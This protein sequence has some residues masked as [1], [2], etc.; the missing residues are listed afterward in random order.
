[1]NRD[2]LKKRTKEFALRIIKLV[3]ALPN[4]SAG[5]V[6]GNQ[7]L[8]SGTSLG[9]NYRAACRAKSKSDFIY[10]INIV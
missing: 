7:L 6:I 4:N 1:M 9:A 3:N 10:K 5:R 8:R 2:E